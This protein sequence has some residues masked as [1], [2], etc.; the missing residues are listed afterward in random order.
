[1]RDHGL[2]TPKPLAMPIALFTLVAMR[3]VCVAKADFNTM[4]SSHVRQQI[5]HP[6]SCF[7]AIP[8]AT[9]IKGHRLRAQ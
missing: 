7:G 9:L 2:L 4:F 5:F 8:T 3:K 1:M 6:G